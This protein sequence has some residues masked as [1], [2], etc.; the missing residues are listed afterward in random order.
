MVMLGLLSGGRA[1][2][3]QTPEQ[4][5]TDWA[6]PTF[7]AAE[8]VSRRATMA[9]I[10]SSVLGRLRQLDDFLYFTGL[11]LPRSMLLLDGADGTATLFMP[12]RDERFEN[13][14]RTNDFPGRPLGADP[15]PP[16]R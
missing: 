8:Y 15:E 14:G 5:Y 12:A 11:E 2:S 9:L 16:R 10:A 6:R 4:R 13:P 3:G 1:V 7:P